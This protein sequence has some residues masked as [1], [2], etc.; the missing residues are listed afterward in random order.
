[1]TPGQ[2]HDAP[3]APQLLEDIATEQVI[4]DK[5]YDSDAIIELIHMQPS[6]E[7]VI[8]PK[9]NCIE[10]RPYDENFYRERHLVECFINKIKHYRRV[11]TCFDKY[12]K[13]YL[14]F[15]FFASTLIWLR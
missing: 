12:A 9:E 11:F 6:A 7:T 8:P 3:L 10:T 5:G 14:D 1:M 2:A 13:R 15:L 4:A